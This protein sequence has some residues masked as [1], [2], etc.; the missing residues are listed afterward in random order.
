MILTFVV[1]LVGWPMYRF[2]SFMHG[3]SPAKKTVMIVD[4]TKN[5]EQTDITI[6]AID[7][8]LKF[9]KMDNGFFPTAAQGIQALVIK[10]ETA[11]VPKH[12][13]PYLPR[14]PVDQWGNPYQLVYMKNNP[15]PIVQSCGPAHG[16]QSVLYRLMRWINL[17]PCSQNNKFKK[18]T[19]D[20][21]FNNWRRWIYR[22][23][24]G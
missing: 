14:V 8:A 13:I 2:Y 5:N 22:L 17:A 24:F 23:T 18:E 1:F 20:E 21:Y 16:N 4:K 6:L 11:P 10:P 9:Y 15:V 19:F 3:E 7:N 12:W